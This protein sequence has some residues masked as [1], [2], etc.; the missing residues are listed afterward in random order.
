MIAIA[1]V[2]NFNKCL[3]ALNISR[4]ILTSC[5]EE[6]T[7]HY[8]RMLCVSIQSYNHVIVSG[9]IIIDL[10][11]DCYPRNTSDM[12]ADKESVPRMFRIFVYSVLEQINTKEL[13]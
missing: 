4:P 7:V 13:I 8:A 10:P 5:Q 3:K 12:A 2:L 11:R 1:T 6:T 9:V